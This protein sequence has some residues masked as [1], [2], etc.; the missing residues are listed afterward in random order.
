MPDRAHQEFMAA[1]NFAIDEA[2]ENASIFLQLWREGCWDEIQRDFPSFKGP[3]PGGDEFVVNEEQQELS[4]R[5]TTNSTNEDELTD[6]K[7][8]CF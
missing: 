3:I 6:T 4:S 2:E 1:I 7:T 5:F 8:G